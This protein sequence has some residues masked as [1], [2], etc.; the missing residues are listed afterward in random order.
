MNFHHHLTFKR[1]PFGPVTTPDTFFA[2]T[3]QREAIARLEF[4]V[5]SEARSAMLLSHRGCGSTTLLKRVAGTSGIGCEAVDAI[6]TT[7]GASSMRAAL[8][9]LA[10]AMSI[11]PFGD[12]LEQRI[13]EAIS[14]AGRS[15]VRTL[16]LIDRCDRNTAKAA[17]AL[18]A[19]H[20]WLSTV[21]ATSFE[22][23]EELRPWLD[24]CPL[25]ID[26]DAFQ[27]G[28]TMAFVRTAVDMAGGRGEWFEDAALVR[29]HELS[30][31]RVALVSSRADLALM[32]A[33]N[34]RAAT[35][36][37]TCVEAIQGELV[38]AA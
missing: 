20:R 10:I 7:G 1:S 31:G 14:A 11:D 33:A 3:P 13:G 15:Q 8:A 29:L 18:A 23:V 27:L 34:Q 35:V 38:R 21:I 22:G 17:A 32:A 19:N 6:F 5:R 25:R 26:L 12:H 30:E 9:R 16:W 2:G 24:C 4:M 36:G 37:S 28:D